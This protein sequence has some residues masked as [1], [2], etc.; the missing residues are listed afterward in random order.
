MTQGYPLSPARFNVVV[1]AVVR[2]WVMVVLEGAEEQAKIGQEVRHQAV[3]IYTDDD[4]VASSDP[5]WLQGTFNTLVGL[6]DRLVLQTNVGKTVRMVFRPFQAAGNQLEVVYGRRIMGEG[7]TYREQ[8]KRLFQ[9]RDCREEMVA[10]S[11]EGRQ[12]TQHRR[13]VEV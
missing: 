4:M 13:G 6:F 10:G 7:S 1:V 9:C 3:L 8:Q 2:Y 5:R 12:M 11:V